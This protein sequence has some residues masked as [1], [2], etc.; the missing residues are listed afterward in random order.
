MMA[1]TE[2]RPETDE[3]F[4]AGYR[5]AWKFV[6]G[7]CQEME[8]GDTGPIVSPLMNAARDELL[9]RRDDTV[10]AVVSCLIAIAGRAI[11]ALA[12]AKGQSV[13]DTYVALGQESVS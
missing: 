9:A 5:I 13:V 1:E 2:Q 4:A 8:A 12:A 10:L 7:A 3:T 6:G 11:V